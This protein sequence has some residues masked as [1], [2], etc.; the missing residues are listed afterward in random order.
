PPRAV[1]LAVN[2]RAMAP[3]ATAVAT[4]SQRP[5]PIMPARPMRNHRELPSYA[6]VVDSHHDTVLTPA[7]TTETLHASTPGRQGRG[8]LRRRRGGRRRRWGDLSRG[9][10]ASPSWPG[11][12]PTVPHSSLPT[13]TEASRRSAGPSWT[14]ARRRPRTG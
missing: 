14:A 5:V 6:I 7:R 2:R 4:G 1:R 8:L 9:G 10:A 12:I 11:S 13:E 3:H